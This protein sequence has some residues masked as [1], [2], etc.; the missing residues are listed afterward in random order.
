MQV[1]IGI[2]TGLV[3]VGEM[4]AGDTREPMAI[5]GETPNIAARFQ[6]I[7]KP[8]TVVLSAATHQLIEGYFVCQPLGAQSL[9]GVMTPVELYQ[10]LG[11]GP[12]HNRLE[13]AGTRGLTPFVGREQELGLLH[14]CWQQA[15][16]G[17]GQ[18][19]LLTGEAGIG[20]SRL[21]QALKERIAGE[22][23]T[24][25]E[26][27]CSPYHQD[28]ALYPAIELSQ[29]V[30]R[31][32]QGGSLEEKLHK[33]ETSIVGAPG[34]MPPH[35]IVPLLAS[36]L[37]L[38]LPDRYLPLTLTPQKQKEKTQAALL[39]WLLQE[40]D[41]Q[42]TLLVWEDLH[43]ADPSTSEL[44]GL[45]LGQVPTSRFL[46]ILTFRP[47]FLPPWTSRSHGSPKA[48]IQRICKKRR[49]S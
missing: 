15:T 9:K 24:Y 26:A 4:G 12:A 29:R 46:V 6:E 28:S 18:V 34:R 42:P 22:S 38:P 1:R 43:W 30:L 47:E 23:V 45:L 14:E 20:K 35:E 36:L 13:V 19:V 37:S 25:L 21:V 17:R 48:L 40:T 2:H 39:T 41:R 10:V 3:V 32:Q 11:E 16:E 31:F 33:L 44:F 8:N 49:N 7:A 5:V 27:S